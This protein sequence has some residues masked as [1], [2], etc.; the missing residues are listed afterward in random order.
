M[1]WSASFSSI[2]LAGL[3]SRWMTPSLW[4]SR[5]DRQIC[6]AMSSTR[7]QGRVFSW[8]STSARVW[9]SMY[10]MAMK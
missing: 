5:S 10:S 2:T 3:R 9:P 7:R 8:A 6:W 1:S 4:A